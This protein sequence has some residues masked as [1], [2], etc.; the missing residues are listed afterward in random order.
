MTPDAITEFLGDRFGSLVACNPPDAWQVDASEFRLLVLLSED[1]SW[2]RLLLPLVP[3]DQAQPFLSQILVANFDFTQEVRYALHQEVLWGVFHHDRQSLTAKGLGSAIDRLL[4]L[5]QEGIDPFF[6]DLLEGQL[7]QI[8]QAAKRQGQ[9]L[10]ET[11]KTLDRFYSEGMMGDMALG[12]T[13]QG[14]ALAAW[15]RQLQR[16][17]SEV[18]P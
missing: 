9:S 4:L 2:L 6:T 7:R 3:A 5:K 1:Q 18:E 16:L 15:Q 14:Q 13:Y 11:L 10:E 17:W 12:S 8:I